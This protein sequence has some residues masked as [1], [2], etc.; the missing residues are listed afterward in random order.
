MVFDPNN[1]QH[2]VNA[3]GRKFITYVGL[4]AKMSDADLSVIGMKSEILQNGD[5]H[6]SGRWIVHVKL[7]IL[8]KKSGLTAEIESLGDADKSNTGKTIHPH[9]PRMAETRAIVRAMRI[10]T[11]S[12][13][14]ALDE[15]GPKEDD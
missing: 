10:V 14:T 12:E 6:E 5:D 4:Q 7:T 11:R 3:Q 15:I 8:S 1:K 13:Y 2:V 9:L